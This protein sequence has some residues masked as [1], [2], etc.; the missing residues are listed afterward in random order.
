MNRVEGKVV[1][2]TGGASGLGAADARMLAMHGAQVVLTDVDAEGGRAV[3]EETGGEF[4]EQDVSDEESWPALIDGV[5][6]KYGKLDVLVNNAGIAPIGTVEST[7]T[8]VW[9]RVLA[10]HLDGMFFGCRAAIPAMKK[11]GGGSIINMSSTAAMVGHAP[12]FAYAAAKGGIRSMTK[13]MAIHCRDTKT[14]VRCN[15]IHPGSINTPMVQESFKALAGIEL[16]QDAD[17]ETIRTTMGVGQPEDVANM[18]LYLASDESR[19]VTGAEMMVDFG[20][21]IV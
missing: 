3:A 5:M 13:S 12:Y 2:V 11:G 7:T 4:I 20:G 17:P 8:E 14:G 21:S 9:H 18:V 16:K 15:S 6:E 19:H 10:I 1:I